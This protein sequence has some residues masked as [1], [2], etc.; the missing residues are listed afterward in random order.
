MNNQYQQYINLIDTFK[1]EVENKY[2]QYCGFAYDGPVNSEK[3]FSGKIKYKIL[4]L[5]KETYG[6]DGDPEC[7][8]MDCPKRFNDSRTN[9]NIALVVNSIEQILELPN[10][11]NICKNDN[12]L[13]REL[14]L[15]YDKILTISS[16]LLKE[17]FSNIALIELKKT[18]GESKSNDQDIR[19]HAQEFSN[20]LTKQICLLDP[21]LIFCCGRVTWESLTQDLDFF[22]KDSFGSAERVMYKIGNKFIFHS[23]HPSFSGFDRYD[24]VFDICKN[25]FS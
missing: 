21:D 2:G 16:D 22:N 14:D 18:S 25:L 11:E 20:L 23:Y 9:K 8:I 6:F 12:E 10:F 5:L 19:A 17:S 13:F 4:F 3:W 1:K 7:I 24:V 15:I